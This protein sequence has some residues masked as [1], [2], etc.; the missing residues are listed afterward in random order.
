MLREEHNQ[1]I[2]TSESGEN[3]N[4]GYSYDNPPIYGKRSNPSVNND[5]APVSNPSLISDANPV[6]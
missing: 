3:V 5:A 1:Q 2:E 6:V 4:S